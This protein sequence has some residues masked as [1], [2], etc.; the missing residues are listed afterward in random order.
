MKAQD[1]VEPGADAGEL[2]RQRQALP[3]LAVPADEVKLLVEHR[4]TLAHMVER[5]LQDLAIVMDRRIRIV[6][7]LER[8]LGGHSALAQE[9]REHETRRGGADRRGEQVL[10]IAQQLEVRLR[11]WIDA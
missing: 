4:D 6:E 3:E 5:S 2:W 1:L 9:Q 10:G 7:Q 8:R 11:L